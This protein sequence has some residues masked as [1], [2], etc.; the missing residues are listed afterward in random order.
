MKKKLQKGISLIEILV[1]ITIFA[2][3]GMI[4]SSSLIL[5]MQGTKKSEA[6]IKVRENLNYSLSVVERNLRNASLILN[7]TG[8]S[9][10]VINYTDQYGIS[11][12]FSCMNIGSTTDSFIASG[13][14]RLTSDNIKITACNF[15]CKSNAPNPPYVTISV[16]GQDANYTGAEGSSVSVESKIYLRN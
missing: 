7:C 14:A 2:V 16:T 11:S 10:S 9:V 4:V 8:E 15:V 1:V 3:L 6:M 13:S 5:T 12:S